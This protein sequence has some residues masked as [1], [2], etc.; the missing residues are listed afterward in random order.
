MPRRFA[1]SFHE[2]VFGR[3]R[4]LWIPGEHLKV[5]RTS[6][7]D[8]KCAGQAVCAWLSFLVWVGSEEETSSKALRTAAY[9]SSIGSPPT[10]DDLWW[11]HES[12]I[13]RLGTLFIRIRARRKKAWASRVRPWT[14]DSDQVKA[15]Q[16]D[17]ADQKFSVALR[18]TQISGGTRFWQSSQAAIWAVRQNH[19]KSTV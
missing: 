2:S 13:R 19:A 3:N 8:A 16:N 1:V 9:H 18:V 4:V 17:R 15:S 5:P 10:D 14:Q 12:D 7:A 6:N 11:W